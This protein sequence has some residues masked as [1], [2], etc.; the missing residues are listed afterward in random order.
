MFHE[1]IGDFK[2]RETVFFGK[3]EKSAERE[4]IH[5]QGSDGVLRFYP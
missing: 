4:G 2:T 5:V 3:P 1:E